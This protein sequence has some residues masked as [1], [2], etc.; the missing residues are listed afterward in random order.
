MLFHT[1]SYNLAV[2]SLW[3]LESDFL[4]WNPNSIVTCVMLDQSHSLFVP[5]ILYLK[6]KIMIA[7]TYNGVVQMRRNTN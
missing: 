5:Q 6:I 4:D 3:A 7:P 1:V 2:Y